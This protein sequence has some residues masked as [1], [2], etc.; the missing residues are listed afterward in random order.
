MRSHPFFRYY[1]IVD[2]SCWLA[3]CNSTPHPRSTLSSGA[4]RQP[5]PCKASA[6][7]GKHYS[8]RK[9]LTVPERCGL[10]AC[11][12]K[13]EKNTPFLLPRATGPRLLELH[14]SAAAGRP[15]FL[16]AAAFKNNVARPSRRGG[17]RGRASI[18]CIATAVNELTAA[19]F[20]SE[21]P[22]RPRRNL[23]FPKPSSLQRTTPSL[24][25]EHAER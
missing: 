23:R 18:P 24:E 2:K 20:P 17:T 8:P 9:S 15:V 6:L 1:W 7:R 10:D 5:G 3:L 13:V 21:S 19:P 25:S 4:T 11:V 16:G 12:R 14:Q 22:P